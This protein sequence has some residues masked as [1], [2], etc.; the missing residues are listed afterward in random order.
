MERNTV[1]DRMDNHPPQIRGVCIA[2]EVERMVL[3]ER[4][5]DVLYLLD[6]DEGL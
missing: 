2:A 5:D 1:T 3:Y 6:D 4:I